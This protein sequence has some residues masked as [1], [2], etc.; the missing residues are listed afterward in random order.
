MRRNWISRSS[1]FIELT[2]A[3]GIVLA[4]TP[5]SSMGAEAREPGGHITIGRDMP[6]H[7]AFRAGDKGQATNIA[8][9]RE[10]LVIS[11]TKAT[12]GVPQSL[13]D[14]MLS[15]VGGEQGDNNSSLKSINHNL[16]AA[17]SARSLSSM[18]GPGAGSASQIG[19]SIAQAT[20]R[21]GTAINHSMSPLGNLMSAMP[22]AK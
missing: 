2:C 16:G 3:L 4:A 14:A 21:V 17:G 22:V 11:G 1:C 20:S 8:T 7:N 9:A 6:Q 12:Q 13:S 15:D 10:D 19:S 18:R 5:I